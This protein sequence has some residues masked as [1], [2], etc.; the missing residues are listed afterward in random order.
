MLIAIVAS[1]MSSHLS[2][3]LRIDQWM[4]PER[5]SYFS[6]NKQF[7]FDVIPT[8]I[9][10]Q[11]D[12][13][14]DKVEGV[15]RPGV[16][17]SHLS[18]RARGVLLTRVRENTYR[19]VSSFDL[20]NEV[21]PVSALVTNDGQNIV[22]F[23]DWHGMGYGDNVVVIY[24]GDG[25]VVNNL[26]LSDLVT[27]RDE[28]LLPHTVSSIRWRVDVSID[29]EHGVVRIQIPRCRRFRRCACESTFDIH[30]RMSDGQPEEEIVDRFPPNLIRISSKSVGENFPKHKKH[31]TECVGEGL[32]YQSLVQVTTDELVAR[33]LDAPM[34]QYP[35]R[36]A[37]INLQGDVYMEIGVST[38][39]S[40]FCLAW[41]HPIPFG[42]AM[43]E[44]EAQVMTWC[45][46][47]KIVEGR[48]VPFRGRL[49][50]EYKLYDHHKT[51]SQ[52]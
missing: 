28:L 25:S 1:L 41:V 46:E 12:Y 52:N 37:Q 5:Q 33:I 23:D 29:Q 6:S 10:S 32:E 50:I 44:L 8:N 39:G 9:A 15:D 47:P 30:I 14:S 35:H 17:D 2:A 16:R 27:E 19:S 48:Q 18:N 45:L 4:L 43:N 40:V 31:G 49:A 13:W 21:A 38:E 36:W 42:K 26:A 24:R 7:R 34:P 11:L 3:T 20:R 51:L 22:T